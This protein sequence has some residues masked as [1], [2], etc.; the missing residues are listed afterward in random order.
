MDGV[1]FSPP[2]E[3]MSTL[4]GHAAPGTLELARAM[5]RVERCEKQIAHMAAL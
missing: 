2:N 3:W 4:F 5:E 1:R